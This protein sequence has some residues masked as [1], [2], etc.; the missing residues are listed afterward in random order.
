MSIHFDRKKK[1][2]DTHHVP[3]L[4]DDETKLTDGTKGDSTSYVP[5]C[6]SL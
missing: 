5:R 3:S 1:K 4:T 2:R 6:T